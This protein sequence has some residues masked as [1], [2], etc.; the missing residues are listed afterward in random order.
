[1]Y[2][3]LG[4][5]LCKDYALLFVEQGKCESVDN[6]KVQAAFFRIVISLL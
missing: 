4:L 3:C 6:G 5:S 1:M 2:W